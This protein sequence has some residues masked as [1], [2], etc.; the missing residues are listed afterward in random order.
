MPEMS[1]KFN[2]HRERRI[3]ELHQRMK[4]SKLRFKRKYYI[5]W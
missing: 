1:D 2:L 3:N 5:R 4:N